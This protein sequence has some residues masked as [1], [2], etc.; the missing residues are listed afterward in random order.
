MAIFEGTFD[1][2]EVLFI[3]VFIGYHYKVLT[4]PKVSWEH[5][6]K[7]EYVLPLQLCC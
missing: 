7:Q 1:E 3:I 4:M 2:L 6:I 5:I